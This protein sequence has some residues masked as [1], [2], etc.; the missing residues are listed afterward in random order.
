MRNAS[1]LSPNTS[2]RSLAI[3]SAMYGFWASKLSTMMPPSAS[4]DPGAR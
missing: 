2:R 3:R 4:S 1:G